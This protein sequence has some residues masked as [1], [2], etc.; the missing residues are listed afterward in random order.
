MKTG[1]K[2]GVC[3][4]LAACVLWGM[5][6]VLPV[7]AAGEATSLE[8]EGVSVAISGKQP[9]IYMGNPIEP[10]ITVK[11][12][13]KQLKKDVDYTVSYQ[14]NVNAGIA[15]VTITGKNGYV[16]VIEKTFEIIPRPLKV[17]KFDFDSGVTCLK[18]YDGTKDGTLEVK[19]SLPALPPSLPARKITSRIKATYDDP[20]MGNEKIV[21]I[22]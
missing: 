21:T 4:F 10:N 18:E 8:G 6:G 1:R 13:D 12:L 20:Y 5:V 3:L 2:R 17:D 9:Y 14:N 19:V 7:A 11:V 16:G 22:H 15:T